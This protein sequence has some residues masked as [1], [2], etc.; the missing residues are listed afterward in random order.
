MTH[1]TGSQRKI[2]FKNY[3][4]YFRVH[5]TLDIIQRSRKR[6]LWFFL[7]FFKNVQYIVEYILLNKIVKLYFALRMPIYVRLYINVY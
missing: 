4:S 6:Y 5:I 2:Q 7:Q 1:K 3:I